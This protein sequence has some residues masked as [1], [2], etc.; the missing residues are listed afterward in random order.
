MKSLQ[1]GIVAQASSPFPEMTT[2]FNS[3]PKSWE[4]VSFKRTAKGYALPPGG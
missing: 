1:V 2:R 4:K 3:T